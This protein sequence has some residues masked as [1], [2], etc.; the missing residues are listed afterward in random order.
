MSRPRAGETGSPGKAAGHASDSL[1]HPHAGCRTS[2]G[3]GSGWL[4]GAGIEIGGTPITG[5]SRA[6]ADLFETLGTEV[7]ILI[8]FQ[9]QSDERGEFPERSSN[10]RKL[11]S[12]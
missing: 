3:H 6:D 11:I 7:G 4:G 1:R 9:C 5:S 10:G 2:N 8:E 12:M